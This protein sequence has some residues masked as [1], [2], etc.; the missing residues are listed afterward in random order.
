MMEL[1]LS[2]FSYLR[3]FGVIIAILIFLDVIKRLR[4]HADSRLDVWLLFTTSFCLL[5][6]SLF[7]SAVSLFS[8]FLSLEDFPDGRILS[9]LIASMLII[10]LVLIS[11]LKANEVLR[12][13]LDALIG[14]WV[15]KES[16]ET[17][18]LSSAV[19]GNILIVIPAYNEEHNLKMLLP[20]IPKSIKNY[21]VTILVVNDGSTDRTSEVA[22]ELGALVADSPVNRG[23]GAAYRVGLT[24][25]E[26]LAPKVMVNMD[27]DGQH[28][29]SELEVMI[30]PILADAADM[31]IGSRVLGNSSQ[32][33]IVRM[34]GVR[35]F[36][37]LI[38]TILGVRIT[39]CSSGYRATSH[40]A[41]RSIR[42]VQDQYFSS[43]IIIQAFRKGLRLVERPIHINARIHGE[44]KKG[45]N[46]IYGLR[47]L[48]VILKTWFR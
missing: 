44:S 37:W 19:R 35:F 4:I 39:D 33:S 34:S 15:S 20:Q 10:W 18:E 28:S 27:A 32:Q 14:Q 41:M 23:Q 22:R 16:F 42:L 2:N 30:D 1:W 3:V 40:T 43:E 17:T 26:T 9:L 21:A 38:T 12:M 25:A 48:M 29:P 13:Q 6:V 46:V 11:Q 8:E 7:P 5:F 31:V 24:L 45:H 47:F 36:S